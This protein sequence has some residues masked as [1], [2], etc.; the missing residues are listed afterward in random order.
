MIQAH[1]LLDGI[2]NRVGIGTSSPAYE[3]QVVGNVDVTGELTAASD[4][5]LKRDISSLI[6][7][8][9]L[10]GQLNPVSYYYKS[11]EY[12]NLKLP[13]RQKMGLVAQDV[14]GVLPN[15]VS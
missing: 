1:C 2:N 13:E 14:E 4:K 3:L 15:L 9:S 11:D 10:I 8:M 6:G 12:P 5:V 7:A